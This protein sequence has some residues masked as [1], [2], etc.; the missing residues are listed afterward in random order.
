MSVPS[1][2][3]ESLFSTEAKRMVSVLRSTSFDTSNVNA[4]WRHLKTVLS[5]HGYSAPSYLGST[6]SSSK[7]VKGE[8][9]NYQTYV[10]YIAP[11]KFSGYGNV[12]PQA[13][14]GCEASCLNM[15]G[16][17]NFDQ[18]IVRARVLRTWLWYGARDLFIARIHQEVDQAKRRAAKSNSHFA[19]RLNGT[20]DLSPT[21]FG[22]ILTKFPDVQFY[23]YTKV[24]K[25]IELLDRHDNYHLTY[26]WHD[27]ADWDEVKSLNIPIAVP[28]YAWDDAKQ[29]IKHPRSVTLPTTFQDL[30]VF[31][32]DTTDLRFLDREEGAPRSGAYIVGL[33]AKRTNRQDEQVAINTGFFQ[34][35][36]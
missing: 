8:K 34:P 5:S 31:D 24:T 19:V 22:D 23:D 14:K 7:I 2:Y 28:M 3:L 13:T 35:T 29:R 4:A 26:S 25:R 9:L 36:F 11:A 27:G 17:A 18:K 6:N 15:S 32:G 16:R 20:S 21:M 10:M 33:R 12:C 1:P 30:P